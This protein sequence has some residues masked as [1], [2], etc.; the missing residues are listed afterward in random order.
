[1]TGRFDQPV[2]VR[3]RVVR[4]QIRSVNALQP[5]ILVRREDTERCAAAGQYFVLLEYDVI[6]EHQ[7]FAAL[8]QQRLFDSLITLVGVRFVI[9]VGKHSFCTELRSKLDNRVGGVRV[10]QDQRCAAPS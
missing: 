10:S 9:A 6:L 5:C 3:L 2:C 1:M 7:Q 4:S 8:L